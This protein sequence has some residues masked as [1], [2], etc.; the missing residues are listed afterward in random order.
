MTVLIFKTTEQAVPLLTEADLRDS[1]SELA[2]VLLGNLLPR[3]FGD[4]DEFHLGQPEQVA[5]DSVP[6]E[7]WIALDLGDGVLAV[8]LCTEADR[9]Q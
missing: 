5:A 8:T 3:H 7:D 2:N 9:G 1:T 4:G 6:S